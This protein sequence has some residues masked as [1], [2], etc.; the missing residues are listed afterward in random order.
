MASKRLRHVLKVSRQLVSFLIV[1][2]IFLKTNR[3]HL[4]SY[5]K[6]LSNWDLVLLKLVKS[7]PR[8]L[9]SCQRPISE[10]YQNS[11]AQFLP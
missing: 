9:T 6:P 10:N 2:S 7:Y 5:A 8:A 1:K 3:Q 4:S 11:R